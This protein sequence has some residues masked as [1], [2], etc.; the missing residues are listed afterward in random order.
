[1]M[2]RLPPQNLEAERAVLG[3]VLLSR[4]ALE[5]V[6]EVLSGR[7]FYQPAHEVIF[8]TATAMAAASR[9][10][11]ALTVGSALA[12][13]GE[14]ARCG[15]AE[16]LHQLIAEVP[17]AASAGY[18]ARMVREQ[19]V[20]RHLVEAGV[21]IQQMGYDAETA[22]ETEGLM[23]AAHAEVAAVDRAGHSLES[24]G[25]DLDAM[26]ESL[27]SP[28]VYLPSPW[29]AV[30]DMIDGFRPGALYVIGARPGQGKSI[31][32]LQAAGHM[33]RW[34]NVAVS[35]LEMSMRELQLRML[36][37][38]GVINLTSLTRHAMTPS[39]WEKLSRHVERV[40]A[41]PM[42]IDDRSGVTLAQVR[43][44]ARAVARRGRLA[45]VMVDYLQLMGKRDQ[46]LSQYEHVTEVSKGLKVLARELD[47]PVL[48]LAQLNRQGEHGARRAPT[49]A[50]LRDS[51]SIE[52]DADVVMLL[53]RGWDD[54][55]QRPTDDLDV[56]VA[57]NRH[58]QTGSLSLLWEAHFARFGDSPW[59]Q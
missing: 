49:L 52:Q 48:A 39:D 30:N 34:G 54:N 13:A 40:R 1:M 27:E 58:G 41:M 47:V 17:S 11:D 28:A 44:H 33:T 42:F 24:I 9:P 50:D 5:E 35:S 46:R 8:T 26:V 7:D 22:G 4:R 55:A 16:Y 59:A 19:A 18:Y 14:L 21:R 56:V 51:G 25:D 53:Q 31:M 10:V 6:T 57:K 29:R 3:A 32:G 37:Q 2:D 20:R 36:S 43:A 12:S 45:C 23:E 38:T 15:G